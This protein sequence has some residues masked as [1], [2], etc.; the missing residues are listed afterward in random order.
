MRGGPRDSR[1]FDE[2]PPNLSEDLKKKFH[3][4]LK[5]RLDSRSCQDCPSARGFVQV[6]DFVI[7]QLV[8]SAERMDSASQTMEKFISIFEQLEEKEMRARFE[9]DPG[10]GR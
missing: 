10:D 3:E 6:M 8:C 7:D 5:G 1:S 4:A 2:I 9:D